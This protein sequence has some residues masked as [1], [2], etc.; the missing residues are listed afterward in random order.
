MYICIYMYEYIIFFGYR[1]SLCSNDWLGTPCVGQANLEPSE[2]CLPLPLACWIEV[3]HH[4]A[5]H[6]YTM[7][8]KPRS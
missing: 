2:I 3:V 8:I 7:G 5:C 1:A 6:I 4:H